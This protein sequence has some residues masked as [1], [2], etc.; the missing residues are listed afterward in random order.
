MLDRAMPASPTTGNT[1]WPGF[2]IRPSD[3]PDM[4]AFNGWRPVLFPRLDQACRAVG[5]A[6]RR[7]ALAWAVLRSG[8]PHHE[9]SIDA[10][11]HTNRPDPS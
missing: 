6:A 4:P 11:W 8:T 10:V 7:V 3:I 5:E 1:A 9:R 2:T